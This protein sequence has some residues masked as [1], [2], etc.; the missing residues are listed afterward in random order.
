MGIMG[1]D[2]RVEGIMTTNQVTSTEEQI[3]PNDV[4]MLVITFQNIPSNSS[5]RFTLRSNDRI[6]E[7]E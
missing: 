5:L 1:V 4:R 3:T 6:I 7:M 2:K